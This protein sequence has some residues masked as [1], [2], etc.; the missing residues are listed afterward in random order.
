M[1]RFNDKHCS[2]RRVQF[3]SWNVASLSQ[4]KLDEIRIW[5]LEQ[6]ISALALL[7]TRWSWSGEWQDEHWQYVHSGD[8]RSRGSGILIM[9]CRR[10]STDLRWREC[11]PG[12]LVHVQLRLSPRNLDFLACYQYSFQHNAT[13]QADRL[14]WWEGF[15]SVLS[16][17]STRN[18]L[19][20]AGDFNLL[21]ACD[22]PPGR[23]LW[24]SLGRWDFSRH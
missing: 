18:V 20:I 21:F 17:L 15:E 10:L 6:N 1:K 14:R 8:P 13:R 5:A 16:T 22:H 4:S 23:T 19:A 24:V 11:L 2:R 3:L 7:E 12:R 9:I